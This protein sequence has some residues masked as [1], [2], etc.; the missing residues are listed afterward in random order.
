MQVL[1]NDKGRAEKVEI[2]KSS[3]FNR[4]DESAKTAL[5]RGI[6]ALRGRWKNDDCALATASI[7]FRCAV[8]WSMKAIC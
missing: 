4:L 5:M 1:V 6:Q 8:D 3:G 7:N 2:I